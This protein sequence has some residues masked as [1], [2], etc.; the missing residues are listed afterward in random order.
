M[1]NDGQTLALIILMLNHVNVTKNDTQILFITGTRE[2][3]SVTFKKAVELSQKMGDAISC[4]LIQFDKPA[5]FQDNVHCLI[6]TSKSVSNHLEKGHFIMPSMVLFDD[7]NKSLSFDNGLLKFAAKYVCVSSVVTRKLTEICTR[8]KSTLSTLPVQKLLSPNLRHI[9]FC[10]S[11]KFEKIQ[12]TI[13]LCKW[14]YAKKIVIFVL[15]RLHNIEEF[16]DTRVTL[17]F[18]EIFVFKICNKI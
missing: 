13:Q 12:A 4:G 11:S 10:C 6:G 14:N 3:A 5:D 1:D 15:V 8:L 17:R 7:C 16:P 18:N 2:A 9:E